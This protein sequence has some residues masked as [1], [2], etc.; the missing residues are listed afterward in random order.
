MH[1][2]GIG[3]CPSK[4]REQA[5]LMCL[6]VQQQGLLLTRHAKLATRGSVL[7]GNV[8]SEIMSAVQSVGEG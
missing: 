6:V 7:D 8:Q 4:I 5:H 1:Q 3:K 2:E